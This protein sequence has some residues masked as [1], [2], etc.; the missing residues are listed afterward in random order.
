MSFGRRLAFFF[1]LFVSS[2][3]QR[4]KADARLAA[5]LQTAMTIYDERTANAA[6][7]AKQL[8]KN[9][10]LAIALKK[11]DAARLNTFARSAFRQPGVVAV[12]LQD[13]AGAKLA[14][15]GPRNAMAFT[16]GSG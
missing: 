5:S 16:P 10:E 13:G 14:A 11:D 4:G 9:P 1:L 6:A 7:D 8:A 12:Q 2:D 15:A 3:S